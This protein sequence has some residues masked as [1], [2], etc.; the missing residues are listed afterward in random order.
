MKQALTMETPLISGKD[1]MKND[2]DDGV[3]RLSIPPTLLIFGY[4]QGKKYK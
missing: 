1:S 4:G 2:F 3:V